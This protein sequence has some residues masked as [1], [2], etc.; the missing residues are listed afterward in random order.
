MIEHIKFW[1]AKTIVDL[2]AAAVIVGLFFGVVFTY[3]AIQVWREEKARNRKEV[4][5]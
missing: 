3:G 1:L 2:A 4:K 5:P